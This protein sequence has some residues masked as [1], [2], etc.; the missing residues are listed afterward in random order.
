MAVTNKKKP[1]EKK[2]VVKKTKQELQL[3]KDY[4]RTLYLGYDLS[5]KEI[6]ERVGVSDNS[7]TAW[8]EEGKWDGMRKSL[9]TTKSEQLNNLYNILETQ[10][11]KV[12]ELGDKAT[13]AN[14]DMI[15]KLTASIKNL[16]TET[17]S[18]QLIEVGMQ[19]IR[20]IQGIDLDAAKIITSHF[21][22]FIKSK[23]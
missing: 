10:I 14:A 18:G 20:F 22:T 8:K 17:S 2:A 4:A 15:S 9:L 7:I 6:A 13:P 23:L 3:A 19:F 21:D 12:K 16:E 11:I 1:V 5:Q